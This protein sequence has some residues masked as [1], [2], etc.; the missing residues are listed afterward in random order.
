M[1]IQRVVVVRNPAAGR[2]RGERLWRQV[3]TCLRDT[4][5][6][7]L[8]VWETERPGH[9]TELAR[10]AVAE[11]ADLVIAVGGDGT[12]GEVVAGLVGSRTCLGIVPTGTGNDFARH[13]GLAF[14]PG[15]IAEA[16]LG[17]RRTAVDLLRWTTEDR[18]G[19]LLNV[20]GAGFDAAVAERVNKGFRIL[21]GA[22]AYV[23]AVVSTLAHY[24]PEQFHLEIDGMPLDSSVMLCAV[25]N[26]SS[27]GGGMKIAPEADI[28]DGFFDL[29]V[30]QGVG[31]TEF[32]R[33]F[34]SVFKGAHTH[35]PKVLALRGRQIRIESEKPLPFLADGEIVGTTPVEFEVV[36][37]ALDVMLPAAGP[38]AG[39][40]EEL[41]VGAPSLI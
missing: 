12:I 38:E 37:K 2:G 20:A 9:A 24:K 1:R 14:E 23:G 6:I 5:G 4:W 13:V 32:L 25:A 40:S 21:R 11:G 35:H 8:A 7:P 10:Q 22:A 15:E 34:P 31:R 16:A 17:G 41:L 30:V 39:A 3:E 29:V 18:S 19:Y 36:P 26:A 28:E 27:Y 33:A